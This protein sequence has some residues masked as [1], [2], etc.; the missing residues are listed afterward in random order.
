MATKKKTPTRKRPVRK[1]GTRKTTPRMT[2]D[3]VMDSIR[4]DVERLVHLKGERA[5]VDEDIKVIE[6]GIKEVFK[7]SRLIDVTVDIEGDLS[8]KVQEVKGS[9]YT[10]DE[11]SLKKRLGAKLWKQVT[12]TVLDRNKLDAAIKAGDVDETLVAQCTNA[13]PKKPYIRIDLKK[14]A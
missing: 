11:V 3:E 2:R 5:R 6:T 1:V 12:S 13:T 7:Q 10:L 4:P 14:K 9:T 8:C